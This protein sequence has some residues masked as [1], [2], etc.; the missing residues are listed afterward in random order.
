MVAIRDS[1]VA[2][3]MFVLGLLCAADITYAGPVANEVMLVNER[4]A[5]A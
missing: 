1:L 4:P 5:S 3:G 2:S